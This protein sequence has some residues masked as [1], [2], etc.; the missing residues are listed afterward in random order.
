MTDFQLLQNAFSGESQA[1]L[2]YYAFDLLYLDG[3]DLRALPLL[4]RKAK[5]E[6]LLGRLPKSETTLRYSE[7]VRGNGAR[8]FAEAA[9]LGLEGVVSK[10]ADSVYRSGRGKDW[11][12]SKSLAR[13][14]FVIVGFT[15]PAAGVHTWARCC[16]ACVALTKSSTAGGLARA[17]ASARS[18]I[19]IPVWR[20]SS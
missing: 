10:R 16:S 9:K 7:H 14:E 17:S 18:R 20:R 13:Q 1:P 4:E 5:L 6:A 8:F 3:Q 2:A 11:Q 19:C 12:K 15:D